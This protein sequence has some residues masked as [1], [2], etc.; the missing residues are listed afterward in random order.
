MLVQV[1]LLLRWDVSN[2]TA[3]G[4][5]LQVA[6]LL[7]WVVSNY[8]ADGLMVQ[9][10]MLRWAESQCLLALLMVT[11]MLLLVALALLLGQSRCYCAGMCP[12]LLVNRLM[13]LVTL[14][15]GQSSC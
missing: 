3:D 11:G 2:A 9:V 10:A 8:A 14:I 7:L 13:F 5:M 4:L 6:L 15:L 12:M 1:E